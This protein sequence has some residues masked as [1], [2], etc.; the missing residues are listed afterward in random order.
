MKKT[1]LTVW[2]SACIV[3]GYGVGG[4]IMAMPY[5]AQKNGLIAT[6]VILLVAFAA[7][8]VIHF[9]I[10]DISIKSGGKS[11]IVEVFSKYLFTGKYKNL[12]TGVFFVIMA[13]VMFTNLAAYISGAA[14]ILTALFG[15]PELVSRLIFYVLAASVVVFGLKA[16]G[17][18]EKLAVF[19]IY[20]VVSLLMV[21]SLFHIKNPLRMEMGTVNHMLAYFGM[22]M[23]A[24]SAFF[25]VPQAVKGLN[26][27]AKKVKKAV[28]LGLLNNLILII[29]IVLGALLSSTEVTEVAMIG[30]SAGIGSWAQ[31]AG[32]VFTILAMITSYWAI[33]LAL[34][35]ITQEQLKKD[36][37]L[38]WLIATVPS[39]LLT[40]LNLGG[41]IEFMRIGGGLIG[42]LV[43]ILVIP[44][45]RKS[46]K[47]PGESVLGEKCGTVMQILVILA[48]VLM[49]LGNV[50]TI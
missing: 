4:G 8:V 16:V 11:Q 18:S 10:A 28:F 48:Q 45:Y 7:N 20:A 36:H 13:L 29:L 22:A 42:I 3:T 39:L 37:R 43:A 49:A 21:F 31:V 30:W 2:E 40:F 12:I 35:D 25:S 24:F 46:L 19:V 15:L 23:L 47:D 17:I 26:A 50:V 32:S 5:L 1:E 33:S 38:C 44:A 9:M 27:D 14:E 41:F 6:L 34:A